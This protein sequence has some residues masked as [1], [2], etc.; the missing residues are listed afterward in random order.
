MPCYLTIKNIDKANNK[1]TLNIKAIIIDPFSLL[2][3]Y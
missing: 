2:F 3:P 1:L